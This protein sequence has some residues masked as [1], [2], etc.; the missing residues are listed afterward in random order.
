[1]SA[2]FQTNMPFSKI[3][4]DRVTLHANAGL[5]TLFDVDS[6]RPTSYFVGGSMVYAVT[7]DFNLLFEALAERNES[8]DADRKI[9][10]EKALTL[11]P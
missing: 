5:T 1:G 2:G 10:R 7:R 3:V 6:R 11:S 9:E 8:V 4:S